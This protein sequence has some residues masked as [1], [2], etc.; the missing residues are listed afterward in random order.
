MYEELL[1]LC[2]QVVGAEGDVEVVVV[3]V[4][5]G[6]AVEPRCFLTRRVRLRFLAGTAAAWT[7][8]DAAAC[9]ARSSSFT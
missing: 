4:L 6:A 9:S 1:E 5:A 8:L 7:G 3:T 2:W